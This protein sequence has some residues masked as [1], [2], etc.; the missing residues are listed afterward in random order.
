MSPEDTY[1]LLRNLTSPIVALTCTLQGRHNG[2]IAD[3]AMR[4]SLS[5]RIPRVAVFIQK[6]NLSHEW[7]LRTGAFVMHLLHRE[8]WDLIWR[9]GFFSGRERPDKLEEFPYRLG[10]LGRPVLRDCYAFLECRIVNLMDAGGST[11]FLA[12]VVEAGRG[13]RAK[14]MT[15]AHFRANLP[16]AWRPRYLERLEAAQ[17]FAERHARP[18]ESLVW[19]GP[20]VEVES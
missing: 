20:E 10:R 12:D 17:E 14:V 4:A 11:A 6:W 16:E 19:Q 15:A 18:L 3:S 9:I 1:E 5:P 2:M 7:L 8:Q 13:P